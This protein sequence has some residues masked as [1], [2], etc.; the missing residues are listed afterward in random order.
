MIVVL[1][2]NPNPEQ[3]QGFISWLENPSVSTR[4]SLVWSVTPHRWTSA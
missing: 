4:P 1:K 2:P 3:V